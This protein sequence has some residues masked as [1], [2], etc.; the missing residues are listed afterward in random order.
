V[1]AV[2]DDASLMVPDMEPATVPPACPDTF[3]ET[4]A[5]SC[6]AVA[7]IVIVPDWVCVPIL[8]NVDVVI[9]E[10]AAFSVAVTVRV[11]VLA[12]VAV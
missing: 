3:P 4:D 12:A 1:V 2:A 8:V 10:L 9:D 6:V 7:V 5:P 11:V